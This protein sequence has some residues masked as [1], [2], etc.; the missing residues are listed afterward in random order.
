VLVGWSKNARMN[1][2]GEWADW[3]IGSELLKE[4]AIDIYIRY[5]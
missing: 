1:G 5:I 3:G 4:A 2:A